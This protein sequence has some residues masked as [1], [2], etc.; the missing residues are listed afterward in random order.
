VTATDVIRC[1]GRVPAELD[2]LEASDEEDEDE[3]LDED[4]GS[5]E[6]EPPRSAPPSGRGGQQHRGHRPWQRRR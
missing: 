1:L 2:A 6:P 5:D 4:E 3:L